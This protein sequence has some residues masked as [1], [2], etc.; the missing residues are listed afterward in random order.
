MSGLAEARVEIKNRLGLHVRPSSM[1]AK[2]ALHFLSK[3]WL[4]D[5]ARS[6]N[7]RSVVEMTSLG[8]GLG[9]SL[10]IKADGPDADDAVQAIK[11]IFETGFKEE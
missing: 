4:E 9:R 10:I 1:V 7:A 3:I 11:A 6:A 8:A 2:A 5:G